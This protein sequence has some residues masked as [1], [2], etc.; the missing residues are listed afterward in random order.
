ML[1]NNQKLPVFGQKIRQ[2]IRNLRHAS[3]KENVVNACAITGKQIFSEI[4]MF[5]K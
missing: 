4:L 2:K 5:K 1:K 3:L